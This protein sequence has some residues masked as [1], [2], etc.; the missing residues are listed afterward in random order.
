MCA[1]VKFF[2]GK[3]TILPLTTDSQYDDDPPQHP[4]RLTFNKVKTVEG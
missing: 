4:E 3:R 1:C 2:A